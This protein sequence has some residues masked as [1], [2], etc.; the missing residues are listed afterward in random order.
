MD[1]MNALSAAPDFQRSLRHLRRMAAG[2]A[3][4]LALLGAAAGLAAPAAAAAGGR[5]P[6]VPVITDLAIGKDPGIPIT[7]IGKDPEL[8]VDPDLPRKVNAYDAQ[9][10]AALAGDPSQWGVAG[11]VQIGDDPEYPD[12]PTG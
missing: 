12:V 2:A 8:P 4:A 6:E 10:P 5:D 3:L 1:T 7:N 11:S 9:H